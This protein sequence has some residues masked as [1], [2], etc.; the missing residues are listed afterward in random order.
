ME[1]R[2]PQVGIQQKP[3]DGIPIQNAQ[4]LTDHPYL[5]LNEMESSSLRNG[6][7]N[8]VADLESA[9]W[10]TDDALMLSLKIEDPQEILIERL[11][12]L[13][14]RISNLINSAQVLRKLL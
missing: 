7:L 10:E 2:E 13:K 11:T 5:N 8:L 6:M 4:Q 1:K 12:Y 3:V 14:R 9:L